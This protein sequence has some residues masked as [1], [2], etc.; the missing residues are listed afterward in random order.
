MRVADEVADLV[1]PGAWLLTDYPPIAVEA[2]RLVPPVVD[3]SRARIR[4][5]SLTAEA[6]IAATEAYQVDYV[7]LWTSRFNAIPKYERWLKERF[8][9][10]RTWG[11]LGRLDAR[12]EP[13][14]VAAGTLVPA[15]AQP[16]TP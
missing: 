12:R 4:T 3:A 10:V 15:A 2:D 16:D 8:D 14:A 13:P 6:L 9:L 5:G 11:K 7:L 1:P